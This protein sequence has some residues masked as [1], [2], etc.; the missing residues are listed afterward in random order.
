M[1]LR[2]FRAIPAISIVGVFWLFQDLGSGFFCARKMFVNI[3]DID[4]QTLSG[5]AESLGILVL[6]SGPSHHDDVIAKLHGGV[7]QLAVWA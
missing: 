2:I 4:V 5:L 1:S 3:V 7:V 6:G